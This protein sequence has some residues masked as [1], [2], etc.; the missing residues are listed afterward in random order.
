MS[1]NSTTAP[2]PTNQSIE[3]P[4]TTDPG[5]TTVTLDF[6]AED[7]ATE[8]PNR[9]IEI[10]SMKFAKP[11]LF[12]YAD[13]DEN[14]FHIGI[15]EIQYERNEYLS[16]AR[17]THGEINKGN[18]IYLVGYRAKT[19]EIETEDGKASMPVIIQAPTNDPV[20]L[21]ITEIEDDN[22]EFRAQG[23]IMWGR[24]PELPTEEDGLFVLGKPGWH[25]PV[26]PY[27]IT[28]AGGKVIDTRYS[29]D[30]ARNE[31][32][33]GVALLPFDML[34]LK[35][36]SSLQAFLD[37]HIR[38]AANAPSEIRKRRE[39]AS[40]ASTTAGRVIT[41]PVKMGVPTT[42]AQAITAAAKGDD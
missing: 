22:T 17:T 15:V 25:F 6:S 8:A 1:K 3:A 11:R 40:A 24:R 16:R 13:S 30:W 12:L 21:Q 19:I 32:W 2:A 20:R 18:N 4:T 34:K 38:T 10:I 9:P 7:L 5:I 29:I 27:D 41:P 35:P 26:K 28:D 23:R 42:G 31:H 39:A 37:E 36:N 14:E 33:E